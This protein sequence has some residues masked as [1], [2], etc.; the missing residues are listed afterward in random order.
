VSWT[1]LIRHCRLAVVLVAGIPMLC[2]LE[3]LADVPMSRASRNRPHNLPTRS[4]AF[5]E[6]HCA[7]AAGLLGS[8]AL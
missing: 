6:A 8:C 7:D 4:H 3:M 5:R 1:S 2:G